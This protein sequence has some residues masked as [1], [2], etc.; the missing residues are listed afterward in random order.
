[1]TWQT[2]RKQIQGLWVPGLN[3]VLDIHI[4]RYRNSGVFDDL[5]RVTFVH[6]KNEIYALS[7]SEDW[8]RCWELFDMGRLYVNLEPSASAEADK[9][10][11]YD[12]DRFYT[13]T[14]VYINKLNISNAFESNVLLFQ[15]YAILDRRVGKRTLAKNMD[16]IRSNEILTMFYDIRLNLT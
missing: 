8:K 16:L 14:D 15:I 7:D 6:K 1:M 4:A 11:Y 10:G 13:L 3:K 12:V 9:L 5:G 2:V